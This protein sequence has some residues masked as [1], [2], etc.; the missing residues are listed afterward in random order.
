MLA[1]PSAPPA[2]S[3]GISGAAV[4]TAI[5]SPGRAE[6]HARLGVI[7]T[8]GALLGGLLAGELVAKGH[9]SAVFGFAAVLTE[10][11][12]PPAGLVR[13]L[14]GFNAGVELGQLAVVAALWPV[15]RVA[16]R[17][18]GRFRPAFVEVGSAAVLTLGVFWFLTRAYG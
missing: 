8:G 9:G 2:R 17:P 10:A 1:R 5:S 16:L 14:L 11:R 6:S 7:L 18:D 3:G 15:L 12:L 4:S 13:A